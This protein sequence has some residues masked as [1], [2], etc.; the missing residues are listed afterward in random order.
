MRGKG[1]RLV[2]FLG[3]YLCHARKIEI[4]TEN[5]S[6]PGQAI[7]VGDDVVVAFH[8]ITMPVYKLASIYNPKSPDFGG[9]TKTGVHYEN[10]DLGLLTTFNYKQWKLADYNS[11]KFTAEKEG[12]YFFPEGYIYCDWWGSPL[13]TDKDRRDP[14]PPNAS[15]P[16]HGDAFSIMPSFSIQVNAAN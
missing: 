10:E 16:V 12:L 14:G 5:K 8:G 11:I 13:G 9:G 3:R 7:S 1:S 15:A 4:I 6:R 2:R